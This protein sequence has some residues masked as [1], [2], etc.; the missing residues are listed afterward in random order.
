MTEK[1][2]LPGKDLLE[3]A[4]AVRKFEYFLLG[5]EFKKQTSVAEKQYHKLDNAFESNEKEEDK[6]KNKR[7]SANSD[8]VYNNYFTVYKYRIIKEFAKRSF[9]IKNEIGL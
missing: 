4:A 8:L 6:A 7:N 9:L 5:K 3:K 2:D 1:D